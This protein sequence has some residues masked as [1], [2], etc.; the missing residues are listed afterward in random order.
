ML[1][2]L[3]AVIQSKS[4]ISSDCLASEGSETQATTGS[5]SSSESVQV[6]DSDHAT[7]DNKVHDVSSIPIA[8]AYTTDQKL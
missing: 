1:L 4:K 6:Q 5:T 8:P 2:Q 3:Q 7:K